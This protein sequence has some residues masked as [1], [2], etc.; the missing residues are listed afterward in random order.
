[1]YDLLMI[2][3]RWLDNGTHSSC[4]WDRFRIDVYHLGRHR[5]PIIRLHRVVSLRT[6]FCAT[7]LAYH[8]GT[9]ITVSY[10]ED[11]AVEWMV[12]FIGIL[13]SHTFVPHVFT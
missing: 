2:V 3:I 5:Q 11:Q 8:V 7:I 13:M 9:I 10:L 4:R 12:R 1:M 6:V